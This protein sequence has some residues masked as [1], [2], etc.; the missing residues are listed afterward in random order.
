M[1]VAKYII[2]RRLRNTISN[3]QIFN[4]TATEQSKAILRGNQL[5]RLLYEIRKDDFFK[6]IS[7]VDYQNE[8]N[9]FTKIQNAVSLL[10]NKFINVVQPNGTVHLVGLPNAIAYNISGDEI[11]MILLWSYAA[12][13]EFILRL[14]KKVIDF[15]LINQ[16]IYPSV[17]GRNKG[18]KITLGNA[19]EVIKRRY[20][21]NAFID[22]DIDLRNKI[23][24]YD[25]D[26]YNY[27]NYAGIEFCYYDSHHNRKIKRYDPYKI[28][29][30]GKDVSILMGVLG[31]TITPSFF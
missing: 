3:N 28:M 16:S 5:I 2:S 12:S 20:K 14:L 4:L 23:S 10:H 21:T 27:K 8:F 6:G 18:D 25:F 30:V 13:T 7:Y 31:L 17:Y 15:D 22:I 24:H 11:A 26:F 9:K 1:P 19:L 29:K